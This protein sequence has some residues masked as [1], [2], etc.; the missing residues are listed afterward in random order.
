MVKQIKG[1]PICPGLFDKPEKS[2][3]KS[4]AVTVT[5]IVRL[6]KLTGVAE[7]K[8]ILLAHAVVITVLLWGAQ[9]KICSKLT[10]KPGKWDTAEKVFQ[11]TNTHHIMC[12][13]ISNSEESKLIISLMTV[14]KAINNEYFGLTDEERENDESFTE[15]IKSNF[16]DLITSKGTGSLRASV[17][18]PEQRTS[19]LK[20]QAASTRSTWLSQ[21]VY[22]PKSLVIG[23]PSVKSYKKQNIVAYLSELWKG[24]ETDLLISNKEIPTILELETKLKEVTELLRIET[25]IDDSDKGTFNNVPLDEMFNFKRINEIAAVPTKPLPKIGQLLRNKPSSKEKDNKLNN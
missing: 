20:G 25:E 24:L 7:T 13:I 17:R 11:Q 4:N 5:E 15:A 8:E 22:S 14:Q 9:S 12:K 10:F 23:E 3:I 16:E 18:T 6:G 2:Q 1:K 21:A 19:W